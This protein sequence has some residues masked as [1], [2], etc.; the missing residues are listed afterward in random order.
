MLAGLRLIAPMRATGGVAVCRRWR[1]FFRWR[2]A[3]PR[4]V[5]SDQLRYGGNALALDRS[6]QRYGGAGPAG[7]AG[8]ADAVHVI[9]GMVRD[10]AVEDV[11]TR[12]NIEPARRH[13]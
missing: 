13:I 8:P 3:H 10:V 5:L 2:I 1:M 11:A 9:V 12:R 7:A 6:D 4:N